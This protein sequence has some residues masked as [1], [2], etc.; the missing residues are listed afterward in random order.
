MDTRHFR[1]ALAELGH[2]QGTNLTTDRLREILRRAQE[3]REIAG[4]QETAEYFAVS[5]GVMGHGEQILRLGR[6]QFNK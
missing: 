4:T 2:K 6:A 3:L 1:E 5:D